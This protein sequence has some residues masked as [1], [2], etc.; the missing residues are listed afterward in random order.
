MK[1]TMKSLLIAAV[2]TLTFFVTS[3]TALAGSQY[4]QTDMNF[5]NG[6]SI[7]STR[8][9]SVPAGAKVEVL[10]YQNGWNL[11]R[12]NGVVGY[13]SG[14]NLGDIFPDPSYGSSYQ[15]VNNN[16]QNPTAPVSN[17]GTWKRVSVASGYLALRTAASFNAANEIGQLYS[18]DTVQIAGGYN[19][20]YVWVYSPKCGAYG[21]VNASYLV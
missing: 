16:T 13:I 17:A 4:V 5:R 15:P 21:W 10:G 20:G 6:P 9:G 2:M 14:G 8:I 18:G 12:Y 11:I 7:T 1:K 19:H 3:I